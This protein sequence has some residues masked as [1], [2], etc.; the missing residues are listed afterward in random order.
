M[1]LDELYDSPDLI[2]KPKRIPLSTNIEGF[3]ALAW[4]LPPLLVKWSG[5]IR[6]LAL[7][8]ACK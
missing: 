7:D 2:Y 1:L 3:Q 5:R 4:A 6:E 8:S